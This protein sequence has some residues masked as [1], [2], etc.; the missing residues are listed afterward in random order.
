[1]SLSG[2][3]KAPT[4][5]R[6][7]LMRFGA[8]RFGYYTPTTVITINGTDRTTKVIFKTIRINLE[9]GSAD[10]TATFSLIARAGFTPSVGQTVSINSGASDRPLFAGQIL[11]VVH[12]R[13]N[14]NKTPYLDIECTGWRRLFNRR[15]VCAS[16]VG[17]PADTAALDIVARFTSGFTATH[18]VGGLTV[19]TVD[20]INETPEDALAQLATLAGGGFYIDTSKD[21]HLF[22]TAGELG[23][24]NPSTIT[25][26]L[27]TLKTVVHT[28]DGSQ[29][30]TR[31]TVEGA[32]AR[33]AVAV[34]A[35][36]FLTFASLAVE[37]LSG[38]SLLPET[39]TATGNESFRI[40][41]YVTPYIDSTYGAAAGF[42]WP[43]KLTAVL[44]SAATPGDAT[45]AFTA[46]N[47]GV[48]C[49]T[50]WVIDTAGNGVAVTHTTDALATLTVTTGYGSIPVFIPAGTSFYNAPFISPNAVSN[51]AIERGDDIIGRYTIND[52]TTQALI[53][54]IEGGDG[55]HEYVVVDSLLDYDGMVA[56]AQSELNVFSATA[57]VDMA[58]D[59]E[60]DNAIPGRQQVVNLTTVDAL[61]VTLTITRVTIDIPEPH[62]RPLRHCEASTVKVARLL[63][64]VTTDN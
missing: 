40:G 21:V 46:P 6:F 35:D 63:D 15:L 1:M 30:R 29:V 53:A 8:A 24:A 20:F 50:S 3:Q 17:V 64:V 18:I 38:T 5:S 54:A 39:E 49:P 59:T 7:G 4:Q 26:T 28:Y 47:E 2:S 44:A 41:A 36:G 32:P 61:S 60:D 43:R 55:V 13:R 48:Q 51:P 62:R 56:R 57:I 58:W 16:Y 14:G 19:V 33:V 42:E 37:A 9:R 11:R 52:T 27:P 45:M 34:P 25:N 31:V 10:N 22:G 12:R 23:L